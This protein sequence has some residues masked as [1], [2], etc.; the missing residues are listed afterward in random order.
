M[1]GPLNSGSVSTGRACQSRSVYDVLRGVDVPSVQGAATEARPPTFPQ[2]QRWAQ[3]PARRRFLLLGCHPST[4]TSSAYLLPRSVSMAQK[5]PH[6]VLIDVVRR[7][8]L[9][10]FTT[11]R[12]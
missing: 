1:G 12:R 8:L 7:W 11:A 10:M 6:R 3:V 4:T 9:S 2:T 5:S